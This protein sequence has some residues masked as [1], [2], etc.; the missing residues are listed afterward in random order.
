MRTPPVSGHIPQADTSRKQAPPVTGHLPFNKAMKGMAISASKDTKG[1][2]MLVFDIDGQ[3]CTAYDTEGNGANLEILKGQSALRLYKPLTTILD[4]ITPI[5]NSPVPLVHGNIQQRT[6]KEQQES[7]GV[8]EPRGDTTSSLQRHE[9]SIHSDSRQ[10][11]KQT[12]DPYR[13]TDGTS[14]RAY[15]D[16]I[17]TCR[18]DCP[19]SADISKLNRDG[20]DKR[21]RQEHKTSHLLEGKPCPSE[22]T[23]CVHKSR[24]CSTYDNL[25]ESSLA[26]GRPSPTDGRTLQDIIDDQS[27]FRLFRPVTEMLEEKTHM[28]NLALS[29]TTYDDEPEDIDVKDTQWYSTPEGVSLLKEI[30]SSLS[31]PEYGF[32]IQ[33]M[34]RDTNTQD[35]TILLAINQAEVNY[36]VTVSFPQDFPKINPNICICN[37]SQP[38][39]HQL[40][41]KAEDVTMT[42]EDVARL[43]RS[44][45]YDFIS[46]LNTKVGTRRH[47]T[48]TQGQFQHKQGDTA[49][50]RKY[51]QVEKKQ[52]IDSTTEKRVKQQQVKV[53]ASKFVEKNIV[54]ENAS[55]N[56]DV[57][58]AGNDGQAPPGNDGQAPTG[59]DGQAPQPGNDGQAPRPGNDGQAPQPGNDGQGP[60]PG[61]D[62]QASR[63]GT[64]G[65]AP[66]P[67]NDGQ[68]PQPGNDGQAPPGNDG[69]APTGN[70]GQAPQPG[71][72]GQAPRPGTDGQAPQPGNDAQAPQ[73]GN[74]GQA[75][76]PG[77]DGQAPQSGNDGQ[78]P[79][80]GNDG[81][82]PQPG[83]DGQA[84][85]PGNDG[86]APRPGNDGQ[87]PAPQPGNDGQAPQPGGQQTLQ[88]CGQTPQPDGHTPQKNVTSESEGMEL[89]A[90]H[91]YQNCRNTK[92]THYGDLRPQ[93]RTKF[94][95]LQTRPS[96]SQL[97]NCSEVLSR[98]L[99]TGTSE[100]D[101]T[102]II[103]KEVQNHSL[104]VTQ[105]DKTTAN[106]FG[107][108]FTN[109]T[110]QNVNIV[111]NTNS[112]DGDGR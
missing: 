29:D 108:I 26:G 60:R 11:R 57:E 92:P 72:D 43:F 59:N 94:V 90:K 97:R 20:W 39:H 69:Q 74:D 21:K 27:A 13:R 85:Q 18:A 104:V 7:V 36:E 2:I 86:Q 80:P 73:P 6:V 5:N 62:G 81:Q 105:S 58:S 35:I 19:Y 53:V 37:E 42:A 87:A 82:A 38:I 103:H 30:Y 47:T 67:G 9:R 44:S 93:E 88:P 23:T 110:V 17:T 56:S 34:T 54:Y 68:A 99:V 98:S 1:N 96:T 55:N 112:A 40:N 4:E 109:C 78:A 15:S 52:I 63:P 14:Y 91:S 3:P 107:S 102:T 45:L 70:D 31:F 51:K 77:N 48:D 95:T 75:P 84:P 100:S 32:N 49:N 61:S 28:D 65:Q 16:D 89:S 10:Y 25:G 106:P 71:N 8:T 12:G 76:Q 111:M 79:Q 83:N 24:P 33:S 22:D 66:Q 101:Y 41:M 46:S 50:P 64:D